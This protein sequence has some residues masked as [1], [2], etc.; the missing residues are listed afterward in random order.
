M[1]AET[2]G[3]K[4]ERNEPGKKKQKTTPQVME[5]AAALIRKGKREKKE[6]WRG[7]QKDRERMRRHKY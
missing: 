2:D 6:I 4:Y 7:K 1:G 3:N 5:K